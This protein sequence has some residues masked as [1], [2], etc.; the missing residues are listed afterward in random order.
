METPVVVIFMGG[1]GREE[2]SLT[3]AAAVLP[4]EKGW[5]RRQRWRFQLQKSAAATS[6]IGQSSGDAV[7]Q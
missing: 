5:R 4:V 3:S 2:A 6:L 7:V 1:G